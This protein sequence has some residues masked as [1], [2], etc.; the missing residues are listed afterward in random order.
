MS[1]HSPQAGPVTQTKEGPGFRATAPDLLFQAR[2]RSLGAA[3][4]ISSGWG[5]MRPAMSGT[6]KYF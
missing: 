6:S 5:A 1:R 3:W 4:E 2:L